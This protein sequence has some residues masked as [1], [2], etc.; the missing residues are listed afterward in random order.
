MKKKERRKSEEEREEKKEKKRGREIK[1]TRG[2][3]ARCNFFFF[4]FQTGLSVEHH[5]IRL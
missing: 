3:L 2:S 1:R 5:S 4:H